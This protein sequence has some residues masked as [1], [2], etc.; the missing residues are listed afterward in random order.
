M[1]E[2][3]HGMLLGLLTAA[4]MSRALA[5][6][7]QE[8]QARGA[9]RLEGSF[10]SHSFHSQTPSVSPGLSS[11]KQIYTTDGPAPLSRWCCT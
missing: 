11:S 4:P 5:A 3:H 7:L 9:E 1:I 2:P 6:A 8:R 10:L